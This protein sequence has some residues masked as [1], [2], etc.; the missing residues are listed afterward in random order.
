MLIE[1][2]EDII[3]EVE[4]GKGDAIS[5]LE[6]IGLAYKYGKHIVFLKVELYDRIINSNYVSE[7]IKNLFRQIRSK[8][9]L[10]GEIIKSVTFFAQVTFKESTQR[11]DNCIIINPKDNYSFEFYEETHFLVENLLDVKFYE[12]C[13]KYYKRNNNI[14]IE[15]SYYPLLGGGSTIAK[16]YELEINLKQHFCLA[17]VDSDRKYPKGGNGDTAKLLLDA[18]KKKPFNCKCYMMEKVMEIEN[19]LPTS[20]V[21]QSTNKK[22]PLPKEALSFFDYKKGLC[23]DKLLNKEL[24][25]HWKEKLNGTEYYE[26]LTEIEGETTKTDFEIEKYK[27]QKLIEGFGPNVLGECLKYKKE[28]KAITKE[29]LTDAQEEEW[30]KIGKLFFEWTCALSPKRT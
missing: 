11:R 21:E 8:N 15:Y 30:N 4:N 24:L 13:L 12:Y 27:N 7:Y 23:I 29:D 17:I 6:K 19:L 2:C 9:Y 25:Q 20:V 3:A 18:D 22:I 16:V 28:L 26:G 1:I 5:T 14:Q 10:I